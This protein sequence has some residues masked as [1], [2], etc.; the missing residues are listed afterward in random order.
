MA[1]AFTFLT[2]IDFSQTLAVIL[3]VHFSLFSKFSLVTEIKVKI[4]VSHELFYKYRRQS[5]RT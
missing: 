3:I 5:R 1:L 4:N 2:F